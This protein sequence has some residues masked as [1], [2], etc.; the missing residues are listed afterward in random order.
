MGCSEALL[1]IFFQFII[2]WFFILVITD[3]S[4]PFLDPDD[5]SIIPDGPF[6]PNALNTCTFLMTCLATCNTFVVNYHGRPFMQGLSENKLL[7]Q[8]LLLCIALILICAI[9]VFEPL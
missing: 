2:H 4:L 7:Q 8:S 5:P 3:I 6:N 1:S 9:E